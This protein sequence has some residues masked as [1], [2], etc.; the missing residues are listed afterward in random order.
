MQNIFFNKAVNAKCKRKCLSIVAFP[1]TPS[2]GRNSLFLNRSY[3]LP[4][5]SRIQHQRSSLSQHCTLSTQHSLQP[6]TQAPT[7]GIA[8]NNGIF[9][10]DTFR[11]STPS[12]SMSRGCGTFHKL[13]SSKEFALPRQEKV[14]FRDVTGRQKCCL[15][16]IAM[17]LLLLHRD[18]FYDRYRLNEQM[19]MEI[20]LL[21]HLGHSS[22]LGKREQ[23]TLFF[24]LY[25]RL[26]CIL[27]TISLECSVGGSLKLGQ[28]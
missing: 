26:T 5:W 16:F 2:R 1:S 20:V 6:Q 17:A 19:N 27:Y 8:L 24:V 22:D 14:S 15:S 13:A 3:H 28:C 11:T 18:C 10:R 9:R 23:S 21:P 12:N 25:R 4:T 7:P